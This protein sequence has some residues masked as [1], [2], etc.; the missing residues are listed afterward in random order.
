[1]QDPRIDDALEEKCN[2]LSFVLEQTHDAIFVKDVDRRYRMINAAGARALGRTVGE[3]VGKRDADLLP[4][5]VARALEE[6]DACVFRTGQSQVSEATYGTATFM[7]RT[8]VYRR[9]DGEL[10]GLIGIATDISEVAHVREQLRHAQKMEAVGRLAAGLAHDVKNVLM[11]IDATVEILKEQLQGD[12][13]RCDLLDDVLAAS[14]S[15]ARLTS[16]LLA[17]CRKQVHEPT[18]V[19]V[20]AA[21]ETLVELARRI[22]GADIKVVL[23]ATSG[24]AS[25]KVERGSLEVALLNLAINARDA[26]PG[27]GHLRF[28]TRNVDV[29]ARGARLPIGRYVCIAVS[30]TGHGIDGATRAHIFEPFFTT[31]EPGKGTGLGLAMVHAFVQ[32]SGGEIDVVSEPGNGTTFELYLPRVDD[33]SSP[34]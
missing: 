8:S 19:E 22:L 29:V 5:S 21:L 28:E 18:V 3:I 13:Y 26:M 1:M 23:H 12:P 24:R 34:T 7:L 30:D 17:F 4:E 6:R 15:G 9:A 32:Q 2:L 11:V 33:D 14:R 20:D 10:L 16:Q 25:V 31:K 27:G